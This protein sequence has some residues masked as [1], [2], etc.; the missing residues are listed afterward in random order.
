[1][2]PALA[3]AAP[4]V[5]R[6]W[7][8]SRG[9][10]IAAVTGAA[11]LVL[12]L[13]VLPPAGLLHP[14]TTSPIMQILLLAGLMA[15]PL[16]LAR[17]GGAALYAL[18]SLSAFA[19]I[20][21][22][23]TADWSF[24]DGPPINPGVGGLAMPRDP[25][26]ATTLFSDTGIVGLSAMIVVVLVMLVGWAAAA[27]WAPVMR[28][29]AT[30]K[31]SSAGATS[32]AAGAAVA[33]A[34]AASGAPSRPSSGADRLGGAAPPTVAAMARNPFRRFSAWL[35]PDP[36]DPYLR[37]RGRRLDRIDLAVV[38]GLVLFAFLFRLYRLDTPRSMHF[39]EVYHARSATEW[40]ADWQ[41][42]WTRDTYEWTHPMLAKYLIA[43]GIVVADPNKVVAE[44]DTGAPYHA[45]AVAPQRRQEGVLDSI[46][47]GAAD[48][49]TITARSVMSGE[50]VADWQAGGPVASLAYDPDQARLLVGMS[51][52]GTVISYDLAAF[53]SV[54]GE[55]GPPAAGLTI[56]TGLAGVSEIDVPPDQPALLFR[57]PD[58]IVETEKATGVEL[59]RSEVVAG[60]VGYVP[61]TTGDAPSG[62]FVVATD[63]DRNVLVV[64]DAATLLP[65]K[66]INGNP[67]VETLPSPPVGPIE[68]RG[69][70][71]DAQVWVP[72]GPLPADN[73]HPAVL[74]GITVFDERVNE[75]DTAPLPGTPSLIGWQSVANIIYIAGFDESS[76]QP[77]VWTVQPIGNGG[78]Q[79]AG[80]AAFD[81][82]LLSGQP[83]AMAFDVSDH[84]QDEDHGRLL[85]SVTAEDGSGSLVQIDAG[86]NAFAWRLAGIGFGSML[87]ALIYLLAATMFSRRRIA[88]LAGVFVAVDGM[89]YVMSRIGMNDI[90]V[91]VFIAAAY[92]VFWQVWSGRWPRS[93]WW[94]L[95]L[96][97]VL[98]GLAAAT[99][100][101]GIY[102]MLGI[103]ILVFARSSLGRFLLVALVAAIAVVM[104]FGAPWPFL[105][106]ALATLALA[107][108]VVWVRPIRLE[109]RDLLGLSATIAVLAAVGLA[110]TLAY[111]QVQDARQPGG[112]VELIFSVLARAAQVAWPAYLLLAGRPYCWSSGRC[113][114]DGPGRAIAG[115]GCPESWE[116][117][118]CPGSAPA[119][120]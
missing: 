94:A 20:Y 60:G 119:W 39:D 88:V 110:F 54:R 107:L 22:V 46:V 4:L 32:V 97:G 80:F 28:R 2:F 15:T 82:T 43:A 95:P 12:M 55:R 34:N 29:T 69:R 113:A 30:A 61:G 6:R 57:G 76:Q 48:G 112:A 96:V 38:V 16:A 37:E 45:L 33:V 9:W 66:D 116:G 8:T 91:A 21:W 7:P 114:P 64:M 109:L 117:S 27:A 90:Y 62:P 47:F 17:W 10:L 70:G 44:T 108:V 104:G 41:E 84:D 111:N 26:L 11:A 85:L 92:L 3:L 56:E 98:I 51:D 81:T 24:V 36:G 67:R 65:D 115:G 5:L 73:E 100:W 86:S 103:W 40:L 71:D 102:A 13:D 52:S 79:S 77:A 118:S 75:I 78:S 59:A 106:V 42:G 72:V 120:R 50:V 35:Q 53:L 93:A 63:L 58:G 18:L 31:A 101:V 99:K 83:L 14:D 89:S 74:G 19:N 49:G 68:V 1:M 23:Y 87:V 25:L 105:V